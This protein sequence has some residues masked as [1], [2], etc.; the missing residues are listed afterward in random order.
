MKEFKKIVS[1]SF[2][3]F[4]GQ[5]GFTLFGFVDNIMIGNLGVI[6]LAAISLA[7]SVIFV[8][9]ALGIGFAYMIAPTVSKAQG[10]G[11]K[12]KVIHIFYSGVFL[13]FIVG[14]FL[15]IVLFGFQKYLSSTSLFDTETKILAIDYLQIMNLSIIP[16]MLFQGIKQFNDG[17]SLTKPGMYCL[18]IGNLINVFL[19]YSLI[20][21]KFGFDKLGVEGAAIGTLSSRVLMFLLILMFCFTSKKI[22]GYIKKP[23]WTYFRLEEI[24]ELSGSGFFSSIQILFKI[25]LFSS[26]IILTGFLGAKIQAANQII[27]NISTLIFAIPLSLATTGSI[28]TSKVIGSKSYFEILK[29]ATRLIIVFF[30]LEIPV[31]VSLYFL[32][33]DIPAIYVDDNQTINVVIGS[34]LLILLFMTI[35]GLEVI[36]LGL[37]KGLND[38]K[39]PAVICFLSYWG[40]GFCVSKLLVDN[41]KLIGIWIGICSGVFV[42][43]MILLSRFF[44]LYSAKFLQKSVMDIFYRY[45]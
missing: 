31:L 41:Y 27:L 29:I 42:S 15:S 8:C 4:L 26:S 14:V 25:G 22:R 32:K 9:L 16:T 45:R 13:S 7:N 33:R 43:S 6:P 17:L 18:I 44:Y 36:F 30:T 40:I 24:Y 37:L 5:L 11:R 38:T 20:F 39:I 21:G 23:K 34:F 3:I 28:L 19:N 10:A 35:D 2:P 12:H 1:L